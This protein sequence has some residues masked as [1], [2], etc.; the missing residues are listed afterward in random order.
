MPKFKYKAKKMSGEEI[1]GT[2]E[3]QDKFEL[4]RILRGEE[5]I[6]V[7]FNEERMARRLNIPFLNLFSRVSLSEKVIFTR[8][9]AVMVGAGLPLYRALEVLIRQTSSQKLKKTLSDIL[10]GLSKGR[11]LSDCMSDHSSVF[12]RLYVSMMKAGEKSGK[13]EES[14]KIMADQLNKDATLLRKIKGALIYPAIII[15]AMIGIGIVM[16]IYVVPTLIST[17]AEIQMD[18]PASTKFIIWFSQF[19]SAHSFF[20]L[21][22]LAGLIVSIAFLLRLRFFKKTMSTVVLY[23]PLFSGLVKKI[24]S[25]RTARTLSSLIASGVSIVEALDITANVLQNFHFKNI[26]EEAKKE[27]QKGAT[28][29]SVFQ[30]AEKVFPPLMGE[31]MAVGEETGEL[32]GMLLSLAVFYEEE[33]SEATKDM[34]TVVEPVLMLLIGAVVGFFAYAMMKPMYSMVSAF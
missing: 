1:E 13:L 34:S 32:P 21:G 3:A 2:R 28:I 16:L 14:L 24:N 25:A 26:L 11:T 4:G 10:A 19:L 20:L 22:V 5:Y 7:D 12:S 17:F 23:L 30:K 15:I 6:L 31:M 27:I 33:V 8:N 29:S 18:L 9:L